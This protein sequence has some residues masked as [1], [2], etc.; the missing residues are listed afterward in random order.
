MNH[1]HSHRSLFA[2]RSRFAVPVVGEVDCLL[3]APHPGR[4]HYHSPVSRPDVFWMWTDEQ[5]VTTP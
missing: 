1:D 4:L 2:C 3:L 5:E